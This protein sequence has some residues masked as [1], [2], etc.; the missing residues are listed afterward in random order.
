MNTI[1]RVNNLE[2]KVSIISSPNEPIW[3]CICGEKPCVCSQEHKQHSLGTEC[4][5]CKSSDIW[6]FFRGKECIG[7]PIVD[8][9][10]LPELLE[11][12]RTGGVPIPIPILGKLIAQ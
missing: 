10:E 12:A 1:T 2:K 6:V 5:G 4:A 7:S 8:K 11:L 3:V 9:E